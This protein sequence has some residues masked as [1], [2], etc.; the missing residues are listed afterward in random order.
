MNAEE[1]GIAVD[2]AAQAVAC[3]PLEYEKCSSEGQELVAEYMARGVETYAHAGE[4]AGKS[5]IGCMVTAAFVLGKDH[6]YRRDGSLIR[7]PVLRPP[8]T[9]LFGFDSYKLGGVAVMKILKKLLG[10]EGE[11]WEQELAGGAAGCPSLVRVRH[12]LARTKQQWSTILCFPYDGTRPRSMELDGAT[13]DEPPP[14]PYLEAVTARMG[15]LRALRVGIYATPLERKTW[16]PVLAQYPANEREVVDERVRIRWSV[17]DND[18][19]PQAVKDK[20]KKRAMVSSYWKAKLYGEHVDADTDKAWSEEILGRKMAQTREPL[21]VDVVNIQ[22]EQIEAGGKHLVP[23]AAHV[24][25]WEEPIP[26]DPYYMV[27]DPAKGIREG[28]RDPDGFLIRNRRTRAYVAELT[29]YIGGWALGELMI[30][31]GKRYNNAIA[32]PLTT[33]G[34]AESLLT[35][36]RLGGY[37]NLTHSR[38]QRRPGDWDTVVGTHESAELRGQIITTVEEML[39]KDSADIPSAHAIQCLMDCIIDKNGKIVAAT[40]RHD[41]L[42]ICLGRSE[43][44][45]NQ[46]KAPESRLHEPAPKKRMDPLRSMLKDSDMKAWERTKPQNGNG[47][48]RRI[49]PIQRHVTLDP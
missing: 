41:E 40:G 20:L 14:I 47:N 11:E 35:A 48:G 29:N 18:A 42:L 49:G 15:A 5:R 26:G 46:W 27:G 3:D 37:R 28:G 30:A 17:F 10:R 2:L 19:L 12:S 7:F 33:G 8:V 23:V 9:W 25:I 22:S 6:L 39:L 44:Y 43:V 45:L 16:E 31:M 34:Y 36:L 4:R 13:L 1:L 24:S 38:I 21:R 32:D